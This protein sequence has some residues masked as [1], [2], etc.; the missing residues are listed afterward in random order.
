MG[1]EGRGGL[2]FFTSI[3][4]GVRS[5]YSADVSLACWTAGTPLPLVS[6]DRTR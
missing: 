6:T 3:S 1:L 4:S 5:L 2:G